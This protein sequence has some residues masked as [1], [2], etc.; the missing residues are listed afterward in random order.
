ML[1]GVLYSYFPQETR[2][3]DSF[4]YAII[5]YIILLN[6]NGRDMN[7]VFHCTDIIQQKFII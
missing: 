7:I 3:L 2:Y 1:I 6:F 5:S 4:F